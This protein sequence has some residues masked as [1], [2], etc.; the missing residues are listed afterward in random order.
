LNRK[1]FKVLQFTR[2]LANPVKY[3]LIDNPVHFITDYNGKEYDFLEMNLSSTNITN[4][5]RKIARKIIARTRTGKPI[6]R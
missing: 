2:F 4:S 1:E 3:H 6:C 5:G